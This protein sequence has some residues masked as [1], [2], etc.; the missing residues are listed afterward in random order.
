LK[1]KNNQKNSI[2]DATK[3]VLFYLSSVPKFN[4]ALDPTGKAYRY[5]DFLCVTRGE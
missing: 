5:P 3:W 4:F 1:G 2:R